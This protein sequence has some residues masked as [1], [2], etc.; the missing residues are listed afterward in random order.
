VIA[1]FLGLAPLLS[2]PKVFV[3]IAFSGAAILTWMA[4]G[5][6]RALP[7]L[8]LTSEQKGAAGH[9]LILTGIL[10][11]PGESLLDGVV[12]DDRLGYILQSRSA[13]PWGWCSSLP[14]HSGGFLCGIRRFRR[15]WREAG[16]C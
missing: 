15:P 12:G 14:A 13:G 8:S 1:L 11:S 7:R 4:V 10:M 5:M 16:V 2:Q 6:F 9:P 3:A